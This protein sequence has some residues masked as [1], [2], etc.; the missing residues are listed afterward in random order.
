MGCFCPSVLSETGHF[1]LMTLLLSLGLGA[2]TL[3]TKPSLAWAHSPLETAS[4]VWAH[5][6]TQNSMSPAFARSPCPPGP[7]VDKLNFPEAAIEW[8]LQQ[9]ECHPRGQGPHSLRHRHRCH[10][11]RQAPDSAAAMIESL[12]VPDRAALAQG[13]RMTPSKAA[14]LS[15]DE[16][17]GRRDSVGC[18]SMSSLTSMERA[19]SS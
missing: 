4:F 6:L 9:C 5:S 16:V 18:L 2:N 10:Q 8:W 3:L 12:P 13:R 15:M 14:P 7:F 17:A 19:N 11:R 1:P